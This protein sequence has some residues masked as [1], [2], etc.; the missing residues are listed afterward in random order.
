MNLFITTGLFEKVDTAVIVSDK[1]AYMDSINYLRDGDVDAILELAKK[2]MLEIRNKYPEVRVTSFL[3]LM[4]QEY[5][6]LENDYKSQIEN[7]SLGNTKTSQKIN[8]DI[9]KSMKNNRD[10]IG[11]Y[12]EQTG[13][14]R[15]DSESLLRKYAIGELAEHMAFTDV[16]RR[17]VENP[18]IFKKRDV[19]NAYFNISKTQ[20]FEGNPNE[21]RI[22]VITYK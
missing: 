16:A 14:N 21:P 10:F 4:G 15:V 9:G 22:P 8:S 13:D 5:F 12:I 7:V 1:S 20:E 6:D 19:T 2:S 3:E 17:L 11:R 18:I